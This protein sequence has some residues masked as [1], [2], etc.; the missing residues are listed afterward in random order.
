VLE[1]ALAV[2]LEQAA[3][4]PSK[5]AENAYKRGTDKLRAGETQE[6]RRFFNKALGKEP[7][8]IGALTALFEIGEDDPEV[9]E[10]AEARLRRALA[11]DGKDKALRKLAGEH[12]VDAERPA[13]P[14]K[15]RPAK[16]KGERPEKRAE[17]KEE[18]RQ[19]GDKPKL[20]PEERA[21][22]QARKQERLERRGKQAA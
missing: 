18:R 1:V 8:H 11:A 3:Q 2:V 14:K 6:A 15:D 5:V 20:T 19:Q 21:A 9:R 22:R 17:G 4:V 10:E 16:E 7:A 13:R 12:G